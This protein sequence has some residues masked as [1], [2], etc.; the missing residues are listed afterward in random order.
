MEHSRASRTEAGRP[1]RGFRSRVVCSALARRRGPSKSVSSQLGA[2]S[3]EDLDSAR[4]KR[5]PKHP[6]KTRKTRFFWCPDHSAAR[7]AMPCQALRGAIGDRRRNECNGSASA[8][9]LGEGV[10]GD[11]TL[12]RPAA[13]E[14][15]LP[16]QG[17][18][19]PS[20]S[21]IVPE[22]RSSH[23]MIS[24]PGASLRRS[25]ARQTIHP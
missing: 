24:T 23:G 9:A 17:V 3:A 25:G 5:T 7:G 14:R 10:T 11:A 19:L 1:R 15:T 20:G 4:P 13:A 18:H 12:G 16:S 22:A 8:P 2:D 6:H 21:S